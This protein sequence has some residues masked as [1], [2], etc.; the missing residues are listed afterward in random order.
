MKT[1]RTLVVSP[2]APDT[3]SIWLYKGTMKYFNNGVWTTIGGVKAGTNIADLNTS[4]D[5]TA[6]IGTVNRLLAQLRAVGVL[7]S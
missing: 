3:N 7:I 5:L 4:A 6:V 2:N 1:I